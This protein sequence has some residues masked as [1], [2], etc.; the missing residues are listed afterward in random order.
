MLP[1]RFTFVSGRAIDAETLKPQA[2]SLPARTKALT[3]GATVRHPCA[4]P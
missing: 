2:G 1:G 4:A 3:G